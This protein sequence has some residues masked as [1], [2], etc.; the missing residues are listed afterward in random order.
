M[1]I[2]NHGVVDLITPS[3]ISYM[4]RFGSL[5]GLCLGIQIATGL[6][7]AI[8]YHSSVVLAFDSVVHIVRD[9]DCG[10]VIR[11]L[12]ANGASFMFTSLY[13]HVG[14]GVYNGSY[15]NLLAWN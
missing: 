11:T 3:N 13:L 14:R 10:F 8:H 2:V 15:V 9:V 1:K 5:L 4:W 12:H 6:F 7:L